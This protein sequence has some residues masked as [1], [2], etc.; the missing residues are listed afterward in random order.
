M[1]NFITIKTFQ[2]RIEADLA[3]SMLE[4]E[5]IVAMIQSED[6]GGMKPHLAFALGVRLQVTEQDFELAKELLA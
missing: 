1:P 6:Q 2:N 4:S 3:K 5:G